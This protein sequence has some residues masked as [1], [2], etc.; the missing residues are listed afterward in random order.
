MAKQKGNNGYE[1]EVEGRPY[2]GLCL[3]YAGQ[4][5]ECERIPV[6]EKRRV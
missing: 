4:Y 3:G 2:R 1:W 6:I 5:F